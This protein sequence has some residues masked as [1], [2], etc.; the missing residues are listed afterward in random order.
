[1][2]FTTGRLAQGMKIAH[3]HERPLRLQKPLKPII[4]Y[5]VL[6]IC[7]FFQSNQR[8]FAQAQS[9]FSLWIDQ[10]SLQE[11]LVVQDSLLNHLYQASEVEPLEILSDMPLYKP[12][13]YRFPDQC[14]KNRMDYYVLY[15]DLLEYSGKYNKMGSLAEE[16]LKGLKDTLQNINGYANLTQMLT[17]HYARSDQFEKAIK[18]GY[19]YQAILARYYPHAISEKVRMYNY[20]GQLYFRRGNWELAK[21]HYQQELQLTDHY[22]AQLPDYELSRGLCLSNLGDYY[23]MHLRLDSAR[24]YFQQSFKSIYSAPVLD[25]AYLQYAL[26]DQINL[27]FEL[28]KKDS[29]AY[30][31]DR[32][33]QFDDTY[34]AADM[35]IFK[36]IAHGNLAFLNDQNKEALRHY[37]EAKKLNLV[38]NPIS[39]TMV[40]L[41]IP[42]HLN[43]QALELELRKKMFQRNGQSEVLDSLLLLSSNYIEQTEQIVLDQLQSI[44]PHHYIHFLQDLYGIAI[45]ARHQKYNSTQDEKYVFQALELIEKNN[46][47]QQKALAVTRQKSNQQDL[48]TLNDQVDSIYEVLEY[49]P[50]NIRTSSIGSATVESY[51]KLKSTLNEG[52]KS[53]S[54]VTRSP[55]KSG[56]LRSASDKLLRHFDGVIVYY[57]FDRSLYKISLSPDAMI[58][59]A[60]PK[61]NFPDSIKQFNALVQ[62]RPETKKIKRST[63]FRPLFTMGKSMFQVVAV[64]LLQSDAR[65]KLCI[66]NS[67]D[68]YDLNIGAL[69]KS[70]PAHPFDFL[71]ANYIGQHKALTYH[72]SLEA[73]AKLYSRPRKTHKYAFGSFVNSFSGILNLPL[74]FA[75]KESD[76]LTVLFESLRPDAARNPNPDQLDE[77]DVLH[78]GIHVELDPYNPQRSKMEYLE[79]DAKDTLQHHWKLGQIERMKMDPILVILNNCGSGDMKKSISNGWINLAQAFISAGAHN[80]LSNR[81]SI[82]ERFAYQYSHK[83]FDKTSLTQEMPE[84]LCNAVDRQLKENDPIL[85]HPHFWS[86]YF[87]MGDG[88]SI[89][90]QSKQASPWGLILLFISLIS[91]FIITRWYKS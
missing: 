27:W 53:S 7:I 16:G 89:A 26:T 25:T 84:V 80:V 35:H 77:V 11:L 12:L 29:L 81:W 41:N 74:H 2:I 59:E 39:K 47:V 19:A 8:S 33:E 91:I 38:R 62:T 73:Q 87:L 56:D 32:L 83:L 43:T 45:W 63:G 49:M 70:I 44:I 20:W 65:Q 36:Q 71:E 9:E 1:M 72:Y 88:M 46:L 75:H 52:L 90:P 69:N 23:L 64:P 85:S 58:F 57:F 60:V 50:I 51:F 14:Q 3:I 24:Y 4:F 76:S 40:P 31:L 17:T 10:L 15:T 61:I 78:F 79:M 42:E 82:A 55:F 18:Y 48:L 6:L 30:Y 67:E 5:W 21:Q 86:G 68:L 54:I 22:Q 13:F 34:V 37:G 28:E 66:I